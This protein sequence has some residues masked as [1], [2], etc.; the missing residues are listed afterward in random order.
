MKDVILFDLGNTLVQYYGRA[1]FPDILKQAIREVQEYLKSEGLPESSGESIWQRV[2]K[3]NHEAEDHSVIPIEGRL[4][5][6]FQ[7]DGSDELL[8]NMCRCFMKPIFAIGHRYEDVIPVLQELGDRGVRKAIISNTPWGS[9]SKLWREEIARLG[10][11][12]QVEAAVFCGDVGWR[13]PDRRIFEFTLEKL[14]VSSDE[15]VFVG[16]DPRWDIVGP[17]TIGMEAI[18]IDR[19]GA[20]RDSE[21]KAIRNLY[22]LLDY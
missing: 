10:L 18:L 15:C 3:E 7:I 6:I 21:E 16:D 12:K 2:E 20:V 4:A 11:D 13:K 5:R 22:G 8:K 14:G 17:K 9:P 19:R 1:E